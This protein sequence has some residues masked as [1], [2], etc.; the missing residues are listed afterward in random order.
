MSTRDEVKM[1]TT[2]SSTVVSCLLRGSVV[3]A[4]RICRCLP[5]LVALGPAAWAMACR[6][7]AATDEKQQRAF[8]AALAA[9]RKA[10]EAD[11]E[12]DDVPRVVPV[13]RPAG[14][15]LGFLAAA[16]IVG[17]GV[18]GTVFSVTVPRLL[19]LIPE[20]IGPYAVA[21][22]A[23]GWTAAALAVAP[24]PTPKDDH[25]SDPA[26]ERGGQEDDDQEQAPTPDPGT[27][28]L[29]HVLTAL[30]DAEVS[31]RAGVHLDVVLASAVS[32]G[33]LG[34]G[35]EVADLRGW[36]ESC[37]LPTA[38]KLGMRI[39]GRP[40]TRVGLRVDAATAALG[41]TPTA[42]LRARSE[43]PTQPLGEVPAEASAVPA[44]AVGEG[45][46]E[47]AASTPAQTPAGVPVPAPAPA[48]LR[49]ILGGRTDPGQ[50][51]SP[52]LSQGFVQGAR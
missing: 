45:A 30:S 34:E 36:V 46:A 44:P 51:P 47:T 6:D 50:T 23:V 4:G 7:A 37:G 26:G 8:E 18:L 15:A 12:P 16:S 21:A 31:K 43:A 32:S 48:A 13:R 24:P 10:K 29:L 19:A 25:E 40:T 1:I 42:L 11:P 3:L 9:A 52:A 2:G 33:L 5:R 41:M 17:F 27:A 38:D 14:E 20:G 39:E 22:A 49:L 35:A 28:L